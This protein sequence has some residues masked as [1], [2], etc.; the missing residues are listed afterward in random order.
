MAFVEPENRFLFIAPQPG[1]QSLLAS[2]PA[3]EI[4]YGG[5]R[6]GGKSYGAGLDWE[7]HASRYGDKAK[8]I[9]FRRSYPELEDIIDKFKTILIPLGYEFKDQKKTFV[10]PK[11]ATLKMRFLKKDSDADLY[12]GHEYNWMCFEEAGNWPSPKPLDMLKACLRSAAGVKH[13]LI[14]TGNPGGPGH[15]WLKQRFIDP[16]PPMKIRRVIQIDE[17]GNEVMG[18][19]GKPIVWNRVFIPAKVEDNPKLTQNDPGYIARI[20]DAANGQ[21]WLIDAW[22]HGSWDIVAGGAIDDCWKRSVHVVKPFDI[23]KSWYIDR[24]FDWGSTHPFS[25]GWWAES[26]G[27]EAVGRN[28]EIIC[29]PKGTLFRIHEWYGC[30]E[31]KSNEGLKLTSKAIASGIKARQKGLMKGILKYHKKVNPGP[32]DNEIDNVKDGPS[33]HSKFQKEGIQWAKSDKSSGSRVNGLQLLREH[34][35]ASLADNVED[36]GIYFFDTCV[37]CFS[38]LPIL[39]RDDKNPDD[40]DTNA[41]DHV[42][43]DVRYRVLAKKRVKTTKKRLGF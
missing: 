36:P 29:P 12:Q 16:A 28:G 10:S 25:V 20:R 21:Q 40:V 8:G 27:T 34:L 42:Y 39:P 9:L 18:A 24:S 23:P 32:A 6:G 1:P 41:E 11:G 38:L 37:H 5:A 3:N 2:C 14:Y 35:M 4:F 22:L 13:R 43:D 33:I 7:A 31:G 19:D 26:D 30:V 17:N 15:N